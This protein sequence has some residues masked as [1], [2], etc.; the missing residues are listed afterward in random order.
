M[1][2]LI[3]L[4]LAI[5]IAAA[6]GITGCRREPDA[7]S[8]APDTSSLVS[9]RVPAGW[10]QPFYNFQENE[11]SQKGFELGRKLFYEV[12][13]S[14][15]NTISCGSCHAQF[16]A[17]AHLD[18][19]L[20]HGIDGRFGLRNAPGI[21]NMAWKP[22]YFWD[23]GVTNLENQPQVPIENH[24]EM[25]L[26][27]AGA[28]E[29][30]NSDATYRELFKEA[31]NVETITSKYIFRSLAQFMAAMVSAN[32]RYDMYT[33]GETGGSLTTL[34]LQGLELFR[35]KCGTC[36]KEPLFTDDSY[37]NNG[38]Q[39]DGG[40]NDSGRARIT[41]LPSDMHKFMVPS[42]RN[43]DLTR[44]YMHDGRFNSLDA[45]L[46]HYRSGITASE[47]LDESLKNGIDMTDDDKKAIIA[48]LK[49]LSDQ[50]FIRDKRFAEQ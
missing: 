22:A 28:V 24:V 21:F 20:S 42:L 29:R 8:P 4:A 9:F 2:T 35:S 23:G 7:S 40:L 14:R 15:D 50:T 26:T 36:H 41:L 3:I 37:R 16:A 12:R 48:F 33:R 19:P 5:L 43:V 38:L 46:E 25:D 17:F 6:T 10:P 44:P 32:S 34:E 47:T 11:L 30:I 18:H 31:F 27:L 13:L 39:V 49:T 1:K 45:V